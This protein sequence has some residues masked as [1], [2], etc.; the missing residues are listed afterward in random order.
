[1]LVASLGQRYEKCSRHLLPADIAVT[2]CDDKLLESRPQRR[3]PV[4]QHLSVILP[5]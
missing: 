5:V 4:P 2:S 3:P 1:M